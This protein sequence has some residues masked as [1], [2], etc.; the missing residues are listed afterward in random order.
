MLRR[1]VWYADRSPPGPVAKALPDGFEAYPLSEAD[2]IRRRSDDPEAVVLD[3]DHDP[4]GIIQKLSGRLG[5]APVIAFVSPTEVSDRWPKTC[6]AYLPRP[7]TPFILARA[8]EN[9]F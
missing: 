6:Y 3:L 1:L 2:G 7:V 9:A 4:A 8:L 5:E